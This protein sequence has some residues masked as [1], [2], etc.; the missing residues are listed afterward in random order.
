MGVGQFILEQL[1]SFLKDKSLQLVY[2]N[3]H[4]ENI[5]LGTWNS[6]AHQKKALNIYIT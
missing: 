6:T 3:V 5:A 2:K 1:I 4:N